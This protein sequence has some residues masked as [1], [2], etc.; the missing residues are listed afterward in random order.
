MSLISWFHRA[1][2][3][4]SPQS[5]SLRLPSCVR[6]SPC[7]MREHR[8]FSSLSRLRLPVRRWKSFTVDRWTSHQ[9]SLSCPCSDSCWLVTHRPFGGL[10]P[11]FWCHPSNWSARRDVLKIWTRPLHHLLG[12]NLG[13]S[14]SEL[15]FDVCSL[16]RL[17]LCTWIRSYFQ[18]WIVQRQAI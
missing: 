4:M 11:S 14:W 13:P 10:V 3:R 7:R 8:L 2:C 18:G 6:V 16:H 17:T 5:S 9:G 15:W 12:H 1:I